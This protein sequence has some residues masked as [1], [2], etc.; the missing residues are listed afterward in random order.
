MLGGMHRGI[1]LVES[2]QNNK[3]NL[4]KILKIRIFEE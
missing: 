3:E 2:Y 1:I 4:R